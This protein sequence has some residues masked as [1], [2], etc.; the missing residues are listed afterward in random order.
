MDLS[1]PFTATC[2]SF[3]C[4][5]LGRADV[6]VDR[7][8]YE[9]N[10]PAV[11]RTGSWTSGAKVNASAGYNLS[12]AVSGSSLTYTFSGPGEVRLFGA[13]SRTGGIVAISLDGGEPIDVP[14]YSPMTVYRD[15][16]FT[17]TVASG[18]HTCRRA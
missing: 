18:T 7:T 8:I 9:E 11:T 5:D 4:H 12:S 14:T 2:S 13:G 1:A 15:L 10:G 3:R 16:L 6:A 17:S